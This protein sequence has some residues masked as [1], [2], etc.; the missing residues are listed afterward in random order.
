[1]IDT[2]PVHGEQN[3]LKLGKSK[4]GKQRYRCKVCHR[5]TVLTYQLKVRAKLIEEAGGKCTLCG[6]DKWRGALEFHH[7]D[8]KLKIRAIKVDVGIN[9]LREEVKKCILLCA[10]C[11]REVEGKVTRL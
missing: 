11:H 1:M 4:G 5:A 3:F 7:K 8:P 10:N 6:Y 2:C 9:K